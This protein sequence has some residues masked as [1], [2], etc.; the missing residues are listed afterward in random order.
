MRTGASCPN[1]GRKFRDIFRPAG[2]Q[3]VVLR[4]LLCAAILMV[5]HRAAVAG[6]R[7]ACV[8]SGKAVKL[9]E[10]SVKPAGSEPFTLNLHELPVMA[11]VSARC[12]S[13]MT[14]HVGGALEFVGSRDGVWLQVARDI[15][16]S[17]G[18]VTVTRGAE[19]I[20]ACMRGDRVVVTAIMRSD[21]VLEGEHKRPD[22]YVRNVEVPC[23]ALT[24]DAPELTEQEQDEVIAALPDASKHT[25]WET[26]H[27]SKLTLYKD[28]K[29]K[30]ASRV[31]ENDA[32]EGE[33][34]IEY[35]RQ[36]ERRGAWVHV[37]VD[38]AGVQLRG[39][40]P[41]KLIKRSDDVGGASSWGNHGRGV[42]GGGFGG[43]GAIREG[44]VRRDTVVYA[45]P[46]TGAWGR[47][48]APTRVKVY[49]TPKD[50]WALLTDVPGL[51]GAAGT[52]PLDTITLDP[53]PPTRNK[54]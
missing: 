18:M 44:T 34:C 28:P 30:S 31:I 46:G 20:D 27:G 48:T 3:R 29:A 5:V 25:Y 40:V 24:L 38:M 54:P 35:L 14:L 23:D 32:C 50:P 49:V 11:T 42:F 15:K 10:V 41:T 4:T 47:F 52:I 43:N 1:Q 39:W 45:Q 17:D 36:T 6:D 9:E 12:G 8:V 21:D 7:A 2:V 19:V 33:R 22:V 37:E 51:S 53:A 26:R 13:P 16:T